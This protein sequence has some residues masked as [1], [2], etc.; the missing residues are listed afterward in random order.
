MA[1]IEKSIVTTAPAES[2]FLIYRDVENW[3]LWDPDTKCATLSGGL[4]LGSKGSLTPAKGSTIPM[5]VTSLVEGKSFT[6]TSRT[7]LF[8]MDFDH[9]LEPVSGGTRI[10]H[11]VTFAG[12]LKP[13]LKVIVGKQVEKGLPVTLKNLKDRAERRG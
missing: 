7:A 6:V 2:V 3:N 8:R 12:L 10:T 13:L 1:F 9:E 5:Q 11:R 4:V